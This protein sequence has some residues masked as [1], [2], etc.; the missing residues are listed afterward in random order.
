MTR[1]RLGD[2]LAGSASERALKAGT[3]GAEERR[4]SLLSRLRG[5]TALLRRA[6]LAA[7]TGDDQARQERD[8]LAQAV[9]DIAAALRE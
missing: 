7:I 8:R 2:M 5:Q 3:E 9:R 4:L 6:E 1:R